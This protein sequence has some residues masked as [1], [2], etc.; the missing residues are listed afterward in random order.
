MSKCIVCGKEVVWSEVLTWFDEW[1]EVI[2]HQG[3]DVLDL[4]ER[5]VYQGKICSEDCYYEIV[6]GSPDHVASIL[7][8]GK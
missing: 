2:D 1:I 4:P 5:L 7:R 6:D 3:P 8:G